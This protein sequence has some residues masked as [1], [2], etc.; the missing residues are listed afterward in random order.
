MAGMWEV[1]Q[2]VIS[3]MSMSIQQPSIATRHLVPVIHFGMIRLDMSNFTAG[4]FS[5]VYKA[6]YKNTT[7]VALKILF[8]ME[9]NKDSIIQFYKE[10]QLL[11]DL[12]H[13]NVVTCIGVTIFPPAVG[14][15]MEY[16]SYGSLY[17][18]LYERTSVVPSSSWDNVGN[19][20]NSTSSR[21]TTS[22]TAGRMAISDNLSIQT[23]DYLMMLDASRAIAH[24]HARGFMH[25]DIKSLNFLVT[26]DL[27]LKLSDFGEVRTIENG[28]K[29]GKPPRVAA[30][31]CAPELLVA[32]AGSESYTPMSDVFSLTM[33][34]SEIILK[35]LPLQ[36]LNAN[37]THSLWYEAILSG[38]RPVI[39]SE[40]PESIFDVI[41]RGWK[42]NPANRPTA[43]EI[44]LVLGA[45]IHA[46]SVDDVSRGSSFVLDPMEAGVAR[47]KSWRFS[48]GFEQ[49]I[50]RHE[51]RSTAGVELLDS[52]VQH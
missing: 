13:E 31:W 25:C 27:H 9:V 40:L 16:C 51:N 42:L 1:D 14:L 18:F 37:F 46:L 30:V 2:E 26:D 6:L 7:T 38:A 29:G 49:H 35:K 36:D 50:N 23:Q 39:S 4:G 22:S 52:K 32:G 41:Q 24:V 34:L 17:D 8:Q 3:T 11:K 28:V 48:A 45:V 15:I 10:A 33:V 20:R 12:Q 21:L 43:A 19:W 47:P 44:C 5:R